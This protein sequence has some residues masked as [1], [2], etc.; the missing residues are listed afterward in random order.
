M[1]LAL[2]IVLGCVQTEA[3]RLHNSGASHSHAEE[4]VWVV[5][6]SPKEAGQVNIVLGMVSVGGTS[7]GRFLKGEY[8][9][10]WSQ[11]VFER[12]INIVKAHGH[13]LL[14]RELKSLPYN[15]WQTCETTKQK[16]NCDRV[17]ANF[18]KFVFMSKCLSLPDVTHCMIMDQDAVLVQPKIDGLGQMASELEKAGKDI[19]LANEDWHV[20]GEG[21]RN[22]NGGMLFAKS[23]AYSKKWFAE[24]LKYQQKCANDQLCLRRFQDGNLLETHDHVIIGSGMQYNFGPQVWAQNK[25]GRNNLNPEM[26]DRKYDDPSLQII[27][28]MGAYKNMVHTVLPLLPPAVNIS[29]VKQ[30]GRRKKKHEEKQPM[31]NDGE[32]N[33]QCLDVDQCAAGAPATGRFAFILT[34]DLEKEIKLPFPNMDSVQFQAKKHSMDI[35]ML[36]PEHAKH[37]L[38]AQDK[39]ELEGQNIKVVQVPW[40]IPPNSKFNQEHGWCGPKDLIRLHAFGLKEYDAV[41]YYDTDVELQGDVSPALRCASR[42]YMLTTAGAASPLNLGFFAVK[43]SAELL[44]T[45]LEFSKLADYDYK[46]GWDNAGYAPSGSKFVGAECGQG[47]LHTLFYKKNSIAAQKAFSKT[48][49]KITASQLDRCAWNY[50]NSCPDTEFQCG[51]VRAH[52][53]E[54]KYGVGGCVKYSKSGFKFFGR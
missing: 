17:N 22:I 15:S 3:L 40:R 54:A 41:A 20:G 24:L 23:T 29:S 42:G 27:H 44:D 18:E 39:S 38:S 13:G 46:T 53:K 47:Y 14:I 10:S 1:I 36:V 28:F 6:P 19:L 50:Q 8:D 21:T 32:K 16:G 31:C 52:H 2:F 43:P 33:V 49:L 35:V 51:Q 12:N 45:A 30:F 7:M 37:P 9:S 11:P 25:M 4:D 48:G 5:N 26:T 34:H